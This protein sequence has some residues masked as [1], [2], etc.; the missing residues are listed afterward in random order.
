MSAFIGLCFTRLCV[1]SSCKCL[2]SFFSEICTPLKH[3]TAGRFLSVCVSYLCKMDQSVDLF[4]LINK[5]ESHRSLLKGWLMSVCQ[6]VCVTN[7]RTYSKLTHT[8]TKSFPVSSCFSHRGFPPTL[9]FQIISFLCVC[10]V[11]INDILPH[12]RSPFGAQFATTRPKLWWH[13]ALF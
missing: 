8:Y 3:S 11:F 5:M 13:L 7:A 1:C 2:L 12:L 6:A 9:L 4:V 10:F